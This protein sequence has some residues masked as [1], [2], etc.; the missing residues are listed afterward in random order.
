MSAQK[1]PELDAGAA[2]EPNAGPCKSKSGVHTRILAF[3]T[4]CGVVGGI[5]SIGHAVYQAARDSVIA[6]LI[7]SPDND[8]VLANK[9]KM[10]ELH[11]ERTR[12]VAELESCS[13]DLLAAETA[14]ERLEQLRPTVASGRDWITKLNS[15]QAQMVEGEIKALQ[16]QKRFLA[17]MIEKQTALT[18]KAK[19]D[20]EAGIISRT[21]YAKEMQTLNQMNLA[22]F[23]NERERIQSDGLMYEKLLVQKALSGHDGA[24]ATP[25]AILRDEQLARIEMELLRLESEKRAKQ[26]YERAL[27]ERV[28]N[29]DQ[30]AA[31]LRNR[32]TFRATEQSLDVAFVPYTQIEGVE[33]GAK[34]YSCVWGL[35][36]CEAVGTVAEI[37]PGEVTL[38]DPWG[39]QA[40]GQ[41]AV[42]NL[43]DRDSAKAKSL[44]VRL[45]GNV[46]RGQ[47]YNAT[48]TQPP[49]VASEDETPPASLQV[50][51]SQDESA[52]PAAHL[53]DHS[54]S[55]N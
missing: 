11:V 42:L 47:H 18:G 8:I 45:E 16:N 13:E 20:M 26:A 5:G 41:Y 27:T 54:R 25:E 14:I 1:K 33:R 9:L 35:F 43:R 40:R 6:P 7:L 17:A 29:I 24:P 12:A 38:P 22:L 37:V 30:I 39:H 50:E 21:D 31:D 3:I 52:M 28:A 36:F 10:N 55:N 44:R 48:D 46:G 4:L 32:P 34:I 23:G 53:E 15:R 19:A 51:A 2:P 49:D